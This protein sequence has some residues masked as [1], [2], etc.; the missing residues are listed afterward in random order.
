MD[1]RERDLNEARL[2]AVDSELAA[3]REPLYTEAEVKE[4]ARLAYV[5][6]SGDGSDP[7][8]GVAKA[9]AEWKVKRANGSDGEVKPRG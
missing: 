4:I 8:E 9:L 6:T 3:I 2:D 1:E 7:D 5:S